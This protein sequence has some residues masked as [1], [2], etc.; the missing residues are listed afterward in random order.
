MPGYGKPDRFEHEIHQLD[1]NEPNE[2]LNGQIN[3]IGGDLSIVEQLLYPD[4]R[5]KLE[6]ISPDD[7]DLDSYQE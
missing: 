5:H 3:N 4:S 1:Y 7:Y 2:H 6:K